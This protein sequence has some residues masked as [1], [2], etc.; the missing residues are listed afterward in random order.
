MLGSEFTGTREILGTLA[1]YSYLTRRYWY[2]GDTGNAGSM[3][4]M[5]VCLTLGT[6]TGEITGNSGSRLDPGQSNRIH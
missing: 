2:L 3:G 6:G 4:M 5:A 1:V